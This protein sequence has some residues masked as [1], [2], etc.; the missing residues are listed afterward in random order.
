[1]N[2]RNWLAYLT[3]VSVRYRMLLQYRAAALAGFGTQ[4]FWGA[5]KLMILEAFYASAATPPPMP[6]ASVIAYVWLG[7][8]FL[9]LLP[10]NVDPEIATLIR[11]GGVAYELSRPLHLYTFW[12]FRTVAYRTA[13]TTLRVI[14]MVLFAMLLLPLLGLADWALKPPPTWEAG[15]LFLASM[16]LAVLL[17][18]AVTMLMH[19]ALVWTLSGEGINRIMLSIVTIF[20]GMVVPLPLFPDWMQPFLH[21]QPLRGI[22]D[23]PYRIYSGDILPAEAMGEMLHQALWVVL[24]IWLGRWLLTRCLRRLVVQGG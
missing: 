15:L 13:G 4:L 12:F 24:L 21:W 8:A 2:G 23:V 5:I 16:G 9:G 18:C 3:I 1:V 6:L 7:Q 22:V 20:T 10:W 14:P 19:V 17:A 11:T